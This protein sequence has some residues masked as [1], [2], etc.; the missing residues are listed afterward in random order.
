MSVAADFHDRR[1]ARAVVRAADEGGRQQ[2]FP[3]E[4]DAGGRQGG[5]GMSRSRRA[6]GG[7]AQFR[8]A[9]PSARFPAPSCQRRL[10]PGRVEQ[11]VR[12]AIHARRQFVALHRDIAEG[13]Q[14]LAVTEQQVEA[15]VCQLAVQRIEIG[16]DAVLAAQEIGDQL[17]A[18]RGVRLVAG[19]I[20][21]VGQRGEAAIAGVIPSQVPPASRSRPA[22]S[23]RMIRPKVGA[24]GTAR[25]ELVAVGGDHQR[26]VGMR[27]PRDEDQAH[28]L[29]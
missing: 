23:L 4:A 22:R 16:V 15:V 5:V 27:L 26:V 9:G 2:P 24:G 13:N 19:G 20:A 14:P 1:T 12:Q 25:V 11:G 6:A 17:A 10:W 21:I 18:R 29:S 8:R 28:R 3:L 7:R